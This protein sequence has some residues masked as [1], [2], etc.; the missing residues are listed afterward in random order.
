M[1]SMVNKSS[2]EVISEDVYSLVMYN[3]RGLP[4]THVLPFSFPLLFYFVGF[5]SCSAT[6]FCDIVRLLGSSAPI[7]FMSSSFFYSLYMAAT[8]LSTLFLMPFLSLICVDVISTASLCMTCIKYFS[9]SQFYRIGCHI[10]SLQI[11]YQGDQ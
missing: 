10:Y 9:S 2:R 11:L 8:S 1:M 4:S 3:H 7:T 5:I 6:F